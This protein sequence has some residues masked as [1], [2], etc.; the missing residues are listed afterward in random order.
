[1]KRT[2]FW[3]PDDLRD[4]L[5]A[6]SRRSGVP[7]AELV[8]RSLEATTPPITIGWGEL[9]KHVDR[10]GFLKVFVLSARDGKL[11]VE[12]GG[13]F[14]GMFQPM[15]QMWVDADFVRFEDEPV[16][17]QMPGRESAE[18][19]LRLNKA[20]APPATPGL[21]TN[22]KAAP[23]KPSA[24]GLKLNLKISDEPKP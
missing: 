21:R 20:A 24:D 19:S 3:L 5:A 12:P 11:L 2:S 14:D 16:V 4:R 6:E 23:P 9:R 10:E 15:V 7:V 13:G 17:P 18:Q 22:M 1:M 8:R